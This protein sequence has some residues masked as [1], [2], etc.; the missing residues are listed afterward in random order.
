MGVRHWGDPCWLVYQTAV[1]GSAVNEEYWVL[2]HFFFLFG[3]VLHNLTSP[4]DILIWAEKGIDQF[5]ECN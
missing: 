2:S 1:S 4:C 5:Q 3:E